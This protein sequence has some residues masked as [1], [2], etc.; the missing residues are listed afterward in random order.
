[1]TRVRLPGLIDVHVHLREPGATHKEDFRSGTEAALAGGFTFILDMPNNPLPTISIQRLEEKIRLADAKAVCDVGFHYGT[2]GKNLASFAEAAAQP[3]VYGLKIY[4]NHTTGD[5]LIEDPLILEEIFKAWDSEKPILVHAE[6]TR[7]TLMI[8][9]ARRYGRPL[10]VCHISRADEVALVRAAKT[11]G[12]PISAGVCPHHLFLIDD[13]TTQAMGGYAR[14]KPPLGTNEDQTALWVGITDGT[15]DLLE[16]DH[17]PHTK[18]EKDSENPPFGVPGLE[19][20]ALLL[21]RAV[22]EGR[23]EQSDIQKLLHDNPKRIFTIPDQPE[24]F[25]E[26]ETGEEVVIGKDGYRTKAGWSPFDGWRVPVRLTK[27]VV[28]G[29]ENSLKS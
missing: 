20:A 7:L 6:Q 26:F 17:A 15:I 25:V 3:R 21:F 18:E 9:F 4:A 28:R 22:E 5:L 13:A 27:V 10:H 24:T 11:T 8:D 23:L 12:L 1:M 16:T 2:D 14:M 19:T 29:Q